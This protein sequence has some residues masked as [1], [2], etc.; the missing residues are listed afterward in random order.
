[1]TRRS[2]NATGQPLWK[3]PDFVTWV[4]TEFGTGLIDEWN[5]ASALMTALMTAMRITPPFCRRQAADC[6]GADVPRRA[7]ALGPR[8]GRVE[9]ARGAERLGSARVVHGRAGRRSLSRAGRPA[10]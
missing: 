7:V 8:L 3:A 6:A 5:G 10:R 2:R 9:A 4:R 1:M